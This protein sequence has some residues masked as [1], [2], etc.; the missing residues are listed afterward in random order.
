MRW[1]IDINRKSPRT[2]NTSLCKTWCRPKHG[3]LGTRQQMGVPALGLVAGQTWVR[4]GQG[5]GGSLRGTGHSSRPWDGWKLEVGCGLCWD[6]PSRFCWGRHFLAKNDAIFFNFF[7]SLG[8]WF[9]VS[10]AIEGSRATPN[11]VSRL[12]EQPTSF[13]RTIQ[14]WSH[15]EI[16]IKTLTHR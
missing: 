13:Q 16:K 14:L 11:E 6:L 12:P 8:G 15:G 5:S 9:D 2:L 10:M 4:V 3:Q 7:G 1:S